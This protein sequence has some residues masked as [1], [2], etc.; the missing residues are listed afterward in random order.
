MCLGLLHGGVRYHLDSCLVFFGLTRFCNELR[1][2]SEFWVHLPTLIYLMTTYLTM[3]AK[4][5]D[6]FM[7]LD[8]LLQRRFSFNTL[9]I[10]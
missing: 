6:P 4:V 9:K 7:H 8:L 3:I 2:A 5:L 10:V 1:R